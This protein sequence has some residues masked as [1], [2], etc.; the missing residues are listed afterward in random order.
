MLGDSKDRPA[1]AAASALAKLEAFDALNAAQRSP[2][3]RVRMN[4]TQAIAATRELQ[5]RH[6]AMA[7]VAMK[8]ADADVRLSGIGVLHGRKE[9]AVLA[10]IGALAAALSD[11]SETVAFQARS[12]LESLDA[13]A[14]RKALAAHPKRG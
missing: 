11:K 12:V 3:K 8:D 13:D 5:P 2:S 9:P 6:V 10:A 7:V 14:A 4:V 1:F